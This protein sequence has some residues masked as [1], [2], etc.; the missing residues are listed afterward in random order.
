MRVTFGQYRRAVRDPTFRI[1]PGRQ[2]GGPNTA[3]S[4]RAAAKAFHVQDEAAG[5]AALDQGLSRHFAKPENLPQARRARAHFSDYVQLARS[6]GREAFDFAV[7]GEL[8]IAGDTLVVNI[9]IALLDPNGYAGR[10]VLWDQLPCDRDE[11]LAIAAPAV[12][13]LRNE[14]DHDRV[15]NIEVWHIPTRRR[16]AFTAP[17]ADEGRSAAEALLRRI[18]P[19]P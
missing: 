7:D 12:T 19:T 2:G 1:T 14:L 15:D 6:D 4:L 9:D 5:V 8:E 11:A 10:I 17:E 3:G 16:F 18:R 13:V